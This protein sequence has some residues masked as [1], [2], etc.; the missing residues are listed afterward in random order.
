[1]LSDARRKLDFNDDEPSAETFGTSVS[2]HDVLSVIDTPTDYGIV[3]QQSR[4]EA[5]KHR[6]PVHDRE[7]RDLKA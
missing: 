5:T 2:V 4:P 1:M 3:A 7:T 6:F